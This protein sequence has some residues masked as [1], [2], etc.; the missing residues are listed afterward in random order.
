MMNITCK[1]RVF[2]STCLLVW[3][4]SSLF[5]TNKL[6]KTEQKTKDIHEE[7]EMTKTVKRARQVVKGQYDFHGQ[8]MDMPEIDDDGADSFD[9]TPTEMNMEVGVGRHDSNLEFV[10]YDHAVVGPKFSLL[11]ATLGVTLSTQTS[12]DRLHWLPHSAKTWSGPISVAV[13][14]PDQEFDIAQ[15]YISFLR[16]CFQPVRDNVVFSLVHPMQKPPRSAGI[17]T[18]NWLFPC[19]DPGSVLTSLTRRVFTRDY[20]AWRTGYNYPQNHL[21]NIARENSMTHYTMSLD[22]DIIP[23]P[24]MAKPL[25]RFLNGNTCAKC[26]FVIPT[27][28]IHDKASFPANKSDLGRL[29]KMLRAQPFHS[30]VFIHNQFATNFSQ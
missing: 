13:F 27:Y 21:R 17:E 7:E 28:E 8:L 25:S 26:A 3:C 30:K 20:A 24:D 22:V 5:I 1:S 2:I 15:A 6:L 14:V 23:S 16:S 4:F 18:T 9:P 29:I 19:S 11:S 12:V 10:I